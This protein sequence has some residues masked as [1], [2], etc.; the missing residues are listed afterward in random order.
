MKKITMSIWFASFVIVHFSRS[1][2]ITETFGTGANQFSIEFVQ[3]G[4]PGNTADTTG[5]PNPVGSVSYVY[6]IGKYEI[7][8]DSFNKA[9]Q[10][11]GLGLLIGDMSP[12]SANSP[13][14]PA[15]G[16]S[17]FSAAK[18]VNYL[19]V[20]TGNQAAY[21]FDTFGTFKLWTFGDNGFDSEN[22]FRNKNAKFFLP[23]VDEWYKAAYSDKQGVWF[24]FANGSDTSHRPWP[25]ELW[26]RCFASPFIRALRT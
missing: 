10:E 6:N 12:Y 3:I 15:T 21:N 7:N 22:P 16:I 23:S 19:N 18:F 14:R 13:N 9:N 1:Q 25:Q 2:T 17:W 20:A 5:S 26:E 8:R 4:N 24:N 11:G